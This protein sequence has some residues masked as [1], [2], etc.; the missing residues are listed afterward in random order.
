MDGSASPD[1]SICIASYRRP[2]GLARLL[3]GL[4]RQKLPD[5]FSLEILVVDNDAEGMARSSVSEGLAGAPNIRWFAEPRQNI[6]HARNRALDEARGRFIAF[7]DDDEESAENWLAAYWEWVER[8]AADGFFG[9]VLPRLEVP[10]KPWLDPETFFS[11]PRHASGTELRVA[12][13]STSNALVRRSLFDGRRFDP[14]WGRTGGEDVE[15]FDR[16]M[17]SGARFVWCDDAV[18]F[19]TIPAHRYRLSWLTRRAFNGGVGHTRLM[20]GRDDRSDR[21]LRMFRAGLA[22]VGMTACLPL[23]ALAGRRAAARLWL[24]SCTQL[25]HLWAAAGGVYIE[26]RGAKEGRLRE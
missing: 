21:I 7:I 14:D 9:P 18:V 6:S 20:S 16:M 4:A 2:R 1:V 8:D 3:A 17:R 13:V 22:W 19:E 15:L 26:Y 25:G 23:V 11:R 24:R 12:E 10:T 5:G